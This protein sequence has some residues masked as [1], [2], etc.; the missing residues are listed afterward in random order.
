MSAALVVLVALAVLAIAVVSMTVKIVPQARAGIVERF[1]KY[2]TTLPAGLNI[3][4]PFVDKVR[5]MIDPREQVVS[6]PRRARQRHRQVGHPRQPRRAQGHR[7][8]AHD[9]RRD[10]KADARRA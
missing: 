5:Y 4:M 7:P 2:R 6:F 3:V 8:A 10:G 9:H 1:G